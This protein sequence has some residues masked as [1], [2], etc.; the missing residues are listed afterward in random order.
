MFTYLKSKGRLYAIVKEYN[1][2]LKD[3]VGNTLLMSGCEINTMKVD[4]SA[5]D[6]HTFI[7]T[8]IVKYDGDYRVQA[9]IADIDFT[10]NKI[11]KLHPL[12]LIR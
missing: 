11:N 6:E 5:F 3:L 8:C 10:N 9:V 4:T 7:G 12:L 2:S 1:G